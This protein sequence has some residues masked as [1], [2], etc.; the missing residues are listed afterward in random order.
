MYIIPQPTINVSRPAKPRIR[1][2]T[3]LTRALLGVLATIV[4][5]GTGIFVFVV[6]RD[7]GLPQMFSGDSLTPTAAAELFGLVF[8]VVGAGAALHWLI[9]RMFRKRTE[10]PVTRSKSGV[11]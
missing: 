6:G 7:F 10:D 1:S 3:M 8:I 11:D 5:V 4:A 9:R 2:H